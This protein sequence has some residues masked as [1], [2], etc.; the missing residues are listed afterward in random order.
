[1]DRNTQL[2]RERAEAQLREWKG[3]LEAWE[4]KLDQ[5]R[6]DAEE[7][8]RETLQ[9]LRKRVDDARDQL[10]KLENQGKDAT[11]ELR[12]SFDKAWKDLEEG[13]DKARNR[14]DR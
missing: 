8:A 11:G 6:L 4:A 5:R 9:Q 10:N 14:F 7:D 13:F 3:R 2:L 1:M 12:K